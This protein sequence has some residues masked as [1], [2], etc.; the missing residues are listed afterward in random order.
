MKLVTVFFDLEAPFLWNRR[1]AKIDIEGVVERISE[2]LSRFGVKAAFNVCGLV[3]ER[4]P[5]I[6]VKLYEEGHEISSHGYAHE[7]F[8]EITPSQLDKVLQKTERT[9]WNLTGEKPVGVRSPWLMWNEQIYRVIERRGYL[10]VSNLSVPFRM[11]RAHLDSHAV[12]PLKWIIHKMAYNIKWQF[13]KKEPFRVGDLIEIP[14]TSP[15]DIFCIYP[16]PDPLKDSPSKSL[17]E[18]YETLVKHYNLSR[19]YFNLNFHPHTIGTRNRILLLSRT[20]RYLSSQQ[21]VCFILP[22]Q[23]IKSL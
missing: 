21:D 14:L 6:V 13:H 17:E 10:W 20:L 7:N 9:L 23:L 19:R 4:F 5:E 2:V 1:R 8:L 18:A 11:T 15:L 3:G 22:R 16:F 12:S